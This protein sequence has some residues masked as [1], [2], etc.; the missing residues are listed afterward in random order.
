MKYIS[1]PL[2]Y[3]LE[4]KIR[5]SL[6]NSGEY[7]R[8]SKI[9]YQGKLH[10]IIKQAKSKQIL[11]EPGSLLFSKINANQNAFC[12]YSGDEPI[13]SSFHYLS[14]SVDTKII[15]PE[16]LLYLLQTQEASSQIRKLYKTGIKTEISSRE[17]VK[18]SIE[19]PPDREDQLVLLKKIKQEMDWADSVIHHT[20][21]IENSIRP[22][23]QSWLKKML[24]ESVSG[25]SESK[26][27]V[28]SE[29]ADLKVGKTPAVESFSK[30]GIPFI[31]MQQI[32]GNRIQ[33]EGLKFYIEE[34]CFRDLFSRTYLQAGDVIMNIVG[35]PLGKIALIPEG[36][37]IS[38]YNQAITRIRPLYPHSENWI[39]WYLAE[40]SIIASLPKK[41]NAGQINISV[42]DIK[43]LKIP[44]PSEEDRIALSKQAQGLFDTFQNITQKLTDLRSKTKLLKTKIVDHCLNQESKNDLEKD[45]NQL[46]K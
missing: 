22:F 26:I 13:T 4:T 33:I 29:I 45:T 8:I 39:F 30:K 36:F 37:P 17:L 19:F 34:V 31:K 10:L 18:I 1:R 32:Q 43:A 3:F 14:Y 44:F 38:A 35:P 6:T 23:F 7:Q 41:G 25:D 24:R 46:N 5:Q 20:I 16:L 12:L 2:H 42:K 40:D 28:L 27:C 21:K 15:Y 11:I 9:D